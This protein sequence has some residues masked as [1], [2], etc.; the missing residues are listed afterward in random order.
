MKKGL[1]KVFL[2]QLKLSFD[3]FNYDQNKNIQE[4]SSIEN[5][6]LLY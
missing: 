2:F 1:E 4:L 3:Q 5:R 6:I